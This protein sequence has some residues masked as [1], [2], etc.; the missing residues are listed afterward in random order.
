[1]S[2][3]VS[4]GLRLLVA[5]LVI[6][7]AVAGLVAFALLAGGPGA[8]W[9]VI[10]SAFGIVC[11]LLAAT[12][13]YMIAAHRTAARSEPRKP[14]DASAW[15]VESWWRHP[16]AAT[17]E[18][19]PEE[20]AKELPWQ[21]GHHAR[22]P[23][24]ERLPGWTRFSHGALD[25]TVV[26]DGKLE[27]GS[28]YDNF[29]DAD[30]AEM[31]SILARN[32]LSRSEVRLPQNLLVV[33]TGEQLV[34]FDAGVGNDPELGGRSFG[35]QAGRAAAVMCAAGIEP[36]DIDVV[37]LTHA[38]PDHCWGLVD[39]HGRRVFPHARVAISGPDFDFWTDRS[40][41]ERE[42]N[43]TL[44]EYFRGARHNLVTYADADRVDRIADGSEIVPGVTA[45]STSGHSPGHMLY[46]ITSQ[47]QT[48]LFWGDL[49]HH[50]LLLQR[51]DWRFRFDHDP[52]AASAQR[53]RV[54]EMVDRDRTAVFAYHFPFPG[55]GHLRP[56]GEGYA[57]LPA[58]IELNLPASN[59]VKQS[60]RMT[61]LC[62]PTDQ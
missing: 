50:Q 51:P 23:H 49:C 33:D 18:A 39:G 47:D 1:M 9:D 15:R 19:L 5:R 44:R 57:W 48:M 8:R 60:R 59:M 21:R 4:Y 24:H 34:L 58:D 45:L 14:E 22:K 27:M 11:V 35:G 10:W 31:D 2:S 20:L 12:V 54:Y 41:E 55:L 40:R 62:T 56:D 30:P 52:T 42:P 29:P 6:L 43:P 25:C 17:V 46:K 36:G 3:Q 61:Y 38:H 7:A 26:S 13:W 32:Y 16:G 28:P 53:R 37:A